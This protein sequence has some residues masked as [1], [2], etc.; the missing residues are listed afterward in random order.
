MINPSVMFDKI[1]REIRAERQS[2]IDR[3]AANALA[4]LLAE[5][6]DCADGVL[7]S[8]AFDLGERMED[9]R[10]KRAARAE[11]DDRLEE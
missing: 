5:N 11:R 3:F 1:R 9:E 7:I 4:G 10:K 6:S 8:R 2:R